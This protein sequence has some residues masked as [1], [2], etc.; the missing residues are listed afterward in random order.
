[1]KR[2]TT[3]AAILASIFLLNSPAFAASQESGSFSISMT[4]PVI[5]DIEA[6][7]FVVDKDDNIIRGVVHE[8]CN[9][10]QGFQ[11]IAG[12]R[13]LENGEQVNLDYDGTASSL[14]ASGLSNIAFR[15]GAR[16]GPVPVAI[17]PQ[18]IVENFT[19]SFAITA[20]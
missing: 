2:I 14:D 8:Y 16:I 3:C 10:S 7:D 6:A 4:V 13:P 11:V 20:I 15:S 1:M 9:S 12:H 17:R 18:G 19:V 5:C